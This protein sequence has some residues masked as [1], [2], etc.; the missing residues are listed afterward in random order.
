MR[1]TLAA[2]GL[3]LAMV[4]VL[5][6]T[7]PASAAV[8]TSAAPGFGIGATGVVL[9]SPVLADIDADGQNEL[10]FGARNGHLYAYNGDGSPAFAPAKVVVGADPNGSPTAVESSPA[11][12]D[13]TGDGIPEIV[14]GAG[15]LNVTGQHGG[16]VILNA[17]GTRRCA[18]QTEDKFNQWGG[19][20][21]DGFSEAVINSPAIGDVN[22]DGVNDIVFGSFDHKIYVINGSCGEIARFDN[23]DT[24]WSAPALAD[25][26]RDGKADIFI[27]GDATKSLQGLPHGGG[28]YRSLTYNGTGTL[29]QRWVRPEAETFQGGSSVGDINGDGRLEVVTG[30]GVDYCQNQGGDCANSRR[31]WAFHI[32][33][34]SNVPGWPR[35][36]AGA[37]FMSA[38]AIGDLNADGKNDVVI[39]TKGPSGQANDGYVVALSGAGGELWSKDVNDQVLSSPTLGDVDGDGKTDVV[40]GYGAGM[41]VLNGANGADIAT[42]QARVGGQVHQNAAALGEWGGQRSVAVVGFDPGTPGPFHQSYVG[43]FAAG[44]SAGMVWPYHQKNATKTGADPIPPLKCDPGFGYWL[45]AADGGVFAFGAPFHGSTGNIRLNQAIVGMTAKPDQSGYWFV[46]QDG[47]IFAFGMAGFFGSMGGTPLNKP[48][49]GMAATP[50]GGG[51]WLV[52]SDGGIFAF[53]N[54]DFHGST[55]AMALNKPIIGMAATPRGTGYWLVASDGGVFAFKAPFYGSTGAMALNQPIVGVQRTFTG[56][57]YSFVARDGGMFA[58]GDAQF[59]GS[60]GGRALNQPIVA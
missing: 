36:I 43:R 10:M 58:F 20:G 27:G 37:T 35:S 7:T 1:Q 28:Y 8:A 57:G 24:V 45:T 30:S 56:N 54:A 38:P 22:G 4:V 16:V 42:L 55:G 21:P 15:S 60:M 19:G 29:G 25:A 52:A 14:V 41:H 9:S 18:K 26:D 5:L 40:V 47:G 17:N 11:V 50:D 44:G 33:D 31:V 2:F 32:D 12:G 49:V 13:V 48:I 6:P 23:T 59:C 39:G 3:L 34:G 46:A 53:G 51:Y